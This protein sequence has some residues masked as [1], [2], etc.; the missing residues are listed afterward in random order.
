MPSNSSKKPRPLSS[1]SLT[2]SETPVDRSSRPSSSDENKQKQEPVVLHRKTLS[3]AGGAFI[4]K[5]TKRLGAAE[6][7]ASEPLPSAHSNSIDQGTRMS[8]ALLMQSSSSNPEDNGPPMPPPVPPLPLN[9]VL[10]ARNQSKQVARPPPSSL[11][12]IGASDGATPRYTLSSRKYRNPISTLPPALHIS[13]H[14]MQHSDQSMPLRSPTHADGASA[15]GESSSHYHQNSFGR[16]AQGSSG[17][18]AAQ[19]VGLYQYRISASEQGRAEPAKVDW[20]PIYQPQ[21]TNYLNYS[22]KFSHPDAELQSSLN[23]PYSP[24]GSPDI[25]S[26]SA[27][28]LAMRLSIDGSKANRTSNGRGHKHGLSKFF[29]VAPSNRKAHQQKHMSGQ[30]FMSPGPGNIELPPSQDL[31]DLN[32]SADP[33]TSPVVSSLVGD[34]LARRRI[35]DQLASSMA[36]DRLLEEDDEFTMAISLTPTVAGASQASAPL[37]K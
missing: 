9:P 3:E 10:Q 30:G 33:P 6:Q 18:D 36:F 1:D 17:W 12:P 27:S 25:L 19:A 22:R 26:K 37:S 34:P 35:R 21:S 11:Y 32:I 24:I 29:S 16:N 20:L 13:T 23:P 28:S 31:P 15:V 7:N 14:N 8:Q 2:Y 5:M 4:R